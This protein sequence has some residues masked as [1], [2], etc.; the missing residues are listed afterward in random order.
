[1]KAALILLWCYIHPRTCF[2]GWRGELDQRRRAPRWTLGRRRHPHAQL[3]VCAKKA[4]IKA[5]T[6]LGLCVCIYMYSGLVYTVLWSYIFVR[7]LKLWGATATAGTLGPDSRVQPLVCT[8]TQCVV[9][10]N[11]A[12]GI[13]IRTCSPE[14]HNIA[15]IYTCTHTVTQANAHTPHYPPST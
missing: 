9:S 10:I 8:E 14:V 1:M 3:L 6:F 5:H 15:H 13:R 12:A 11:C 2:G 4:R 7:V